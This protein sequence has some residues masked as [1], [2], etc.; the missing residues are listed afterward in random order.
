MDKFLSVLQ[1]ITPIFL[2][3]GLGMLARKKNMMTREEIKGL[4]QFVLKFGL[5]CVLFN[6]C[7]SCSFG[8]ETMTTMAL[9]IPIMLVSSLWAFR[10]RKNTF[11]YHNFPMMFS[12][13]ESGMLGIPLFMTIF[14]ASEA[15]RVGILDMAQ[16]LIAITVIAILAAAPGDNPTPAGIARQVFRSPLLL[17]SL[18]GLALNLSGAAALL[19]KIGVYPI[20][21]ETTGYLA[22][23]VS[24][25][26][27]FSVGYNFSLVGGNRNQII[28]ICLI[29]G[30][31]FAVFCVIMELVLLLLPSVDSM[32][33]WAI[34]L[35]CTLPPSYI[36]P[37][38]G[39][40]TEDATVAS[41]V[42]SIMTVISLLI[43]CLIA[44]VVA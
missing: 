20:I 6:S 1:V 29:H 12:A 32:T 17:M 40:T 28:K 33:R 24:A 36:S 26:M 7:L 34:L 9:V 21:T 35:F 13:Q 4:Q 42:C 10:A 16:S 30:S 44:I 2:A 31:M 5:P 41:G 38:L 23:P 15:F 39:K 37:T 18:L 43:F 3:V 22:Q 27:L 8:A 11:P 25:L 19:D 14:G